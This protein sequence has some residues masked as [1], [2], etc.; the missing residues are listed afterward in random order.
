MSAEQA[1]KI[2]LAKEIIFRGCAWMNFKT[3]LPFHEMR[4]G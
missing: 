2:T 4:E 1:K 3:K